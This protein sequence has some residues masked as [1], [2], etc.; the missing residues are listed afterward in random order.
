MEETKLLL[1][2]MNKVKARL[3]E[4]LASF[5]REGKDFDRCKIEQNEKWRRFWYVNYI[6]HI[7]HRV[8]TL[9]MPIQRQ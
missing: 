1:E 3:E 7:F 2:K 9:I 6:V 4:K 8:H 5:K